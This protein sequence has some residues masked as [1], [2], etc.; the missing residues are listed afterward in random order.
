MVAAAGAGPPPID[1]KLLTPTVLSSSIQT[2]LSPSTVIAA[3]V[4]SEKMQTEE[5]VRTAVTSFHRHLNVKDLSCDL[6]PGHVATWAVKG[7]KK[8][9]ERAVILSHRAAS[10][11]VE[12]KSI[13]VNHLRL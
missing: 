9:K 10:V 8:G 6:V 11:L 1:I 12:K 7:S 13:N 4:I 3:R 5:G 2:L